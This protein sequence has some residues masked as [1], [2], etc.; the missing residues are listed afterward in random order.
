[1][2]WYQLSSV[3]NRINVSVVG[4]ANVCASIIGARRDDPRHEAVQVVLGESE[5]PERRI[6]ALLHF[7]KPLKQMD[8]VAGIF[9]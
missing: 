1:M 8:A 5:R 9:L 2:S 6:A 4:A 7:R 3:L